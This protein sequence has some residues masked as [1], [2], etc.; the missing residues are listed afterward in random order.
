MYSEKTPNM[1]H[2]EVPTAP[3]LPVAVPVAV[4][5][6][7][8]CTPVELS[9]P[10]TGPNTGLLLRR[11]LVKAMRNIYMTSKFGLDYTLQ[12]FLESKLEDELEDKPENGSK[13][14]KGCDF[15]E[16]LKNR[17]QALKTKKITLQQRER[18]ILC[19]IAHAADETAE[20]IT[21]LK[22]M[23][24][25]LMEARLLALSKIK[26][27]YSCLR[28]IHRP[29]SRKSIEDSPVPIPKVDI[30]EEGIQHL[31]DK[32][33]STIKKLK[34]VSDAI[35]IY[36]CPEGMEHRDWECLDVRKFGIMRMLIKHQSA[37]KNAIEKLQNCRKAEKPLRKEKDEV[38][39]LIEK[40][41]KELEEVKSMAEKLDVSVK[42]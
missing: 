19:N 32:V 41:E 27:L 29:N 1:T 35:L 7:E 8:Q 10:D 16:A 15:N 26:C 31:L 33:E 30:S 11:S 28:Q 25:N 20:A 12:W 21:E 3:V 18:N 24:K 37:F 38:S 4:N 17:I 6:I 14:T 42:N 5:T 39:L 22:S 34:C 13:N 36:Q 9:I 40:A 23:G 2:M